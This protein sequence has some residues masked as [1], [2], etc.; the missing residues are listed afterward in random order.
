[1]NPSDANSPLATLRQL[2]EMLDAG[3]LTPAEFEALKQQLVFGAAPP[4]PEPPVSSTPAPLSPPAPLAFVP[5]EEPLTASAPAP[6]VSSVADTPDWLAA[7]PLP[8]LTSEPPASPG[9]EAAERRNPLTLVFAIGGALVLLSII[10]YLV[11][12]R[13]A[14]PDEH[15]TSASQTAADSA[16]VSPEE[17]PQ[18]QQ[19]TLPPATPETIRVAPAIPPPVAAATQPRPDSSLAAPAAKAPTPAPAPIAPAKPAAPAKAAPASPTPADSAATKPA[20]Q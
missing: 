17:G 18:A 2:K 9:S 8:L 5:T 19:I 14:T 1:M 16:A 6:E 12:G 3:T 15:L 11:M 20:Q 7:A 13:P 10:L 4:A